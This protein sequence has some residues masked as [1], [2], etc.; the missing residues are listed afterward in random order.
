MEVD[1]AKTVEESKWGQQY[2]NRKTRKVS[3]SSQSCVSCCITDHSQIRGL[4]QQPFIISHQST[5]KQGQSADPGRAYFCVYRQL[6][7]WWGWAIVRQRWQG[8]FVS[9]PSVFLS[10]PAC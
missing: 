5:G 7:G 9:L 2:D 6:V 4:K 10:S 8:G 3:P 1:L